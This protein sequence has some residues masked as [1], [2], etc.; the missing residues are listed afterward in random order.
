MAFF[1]CDSLTDITISSNVSS[2][3]FQALAGCD[4]LSAFMVDTHNPAYASM[5]GVLF[6]KSQTTL[7]QYPPGRSGGSYLIPNSVTTIGLGAFM[8]CRSLTNVTIPSSV[9]VLAQSAFYRCYGLIS[10]EIPNNVTNL[11]GYAFYSCSSLTSVT[12]S[13]NVTSIGNSTFQYCYVL[14]NIFFRGSAPS[15]GSFVFLGDTTTTVYYLPGTTNW[16]ATFGGRPTAVWPQVQ[17]SA[18]SSF[19][20]RTNRFGFNFLASS[21][22]VIVVEAATNLVSPVWVPAGT[23]TFTNGSASFSDPGWTNHPAR[24]YRLRSP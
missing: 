2:I 16:G 12:V 21:N 13:S 18:A 5:N 6:N 14:T 17:T 7:V 9:T 4:H 3:E 8:Q 15:L 20:V 11:G 24:F 1:D 23:N 19:G 10:I 22:A